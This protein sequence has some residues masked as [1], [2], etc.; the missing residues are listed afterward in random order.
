MFQILVNFIKLLV[1]SPELVL[2]SNL[3]GRGVLWVLGL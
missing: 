1:G 3:K 2:G